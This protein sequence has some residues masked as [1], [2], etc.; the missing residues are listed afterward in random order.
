M[1]LEIFLRVSSPETS[2]LAAFSEFG[3]RFQQGS[4]IFKCAYHVFGLNSKENRATNMNFFGATIFLYALARTSAV[5]S[6]T[7]SCSFTLSDTVHYPLF[8]NT[9]VNGTVQ[10]YC[11]NVGIDGRTLDEVLY[12]ALIPD[13]FSTSRSFNFSKLAEC[14]KE[15]R[16]GWITT[17]NITI[18]PGA[19]PFL[20]QLESM[21]FESTAPNSNSSQFF[22]TTSKNLFEK[23]PRLR[24]LTIQNFILAES[25]ILAFSSLKN[26]LNNLT[27]SWVAPGKR[28]LQ[29]VA[30]FTNLTHVVLEDICEKETFPPL[31][32]INS[33]S[34]LKSISIK[35]CDMPTITRDSFLFMGNLTQLEWRYSSIETIEDGSFD[36]LINLEELDLAYNK[37]TDLPNGLF[38]NMR[39]LKVVDLLKNGLIS[40][41]S[42]SNFSHVDDF[43]RFQLICEA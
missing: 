32:Y 9:P 21:S 3:K 25:T 39:K 15:I 30:K 14:V 23:M 17:G 7:P 10:I 26:K 34:S 13:R 35:L 40:N 36:D 20:P 18:R 41:L 11:E 38:K 33:K 22:L 1:C 19:L 8:D 43:G 42:R 2:S 12:H 29:E 6:P 4:E 5:I 27:L 24:N 37:I 16:C 28:L 31:T